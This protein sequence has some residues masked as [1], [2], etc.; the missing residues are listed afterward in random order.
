VTTVP[1][2]VYNILSE[3]IWPAPTF[4]IYISPR[5]DTSEGGSWG[6]EKV[7]QWWEPVSLR[8]GTN[9]SPSV[10]RVKRILGK[11]PGKSVHDRPEDLFAYPGDRFRLVEHVAGNQ[12][13][14]FTGWAGLEHIQ[15]QAEP[16]SEVYDWAVYGPEV[17]FAAAVIDGSWYKTPTVDDLEIDGQDATTSRFRD[18]VFQI[19]GKCIFNEGGKPN[20]SQYEWRLIAKSDDSGAGDGT[21]HSHVFEPPD[22][23]VTVGDS[24]TSSRIQAEHWDAA[25]AVVSLLHW[26]GYQT[27]NGLAGDWNTEAR[28][29][30]IRET[31]GGDSSPIRLGE[32]DVTGMSL[33][34]ALTA[35]LRPVG[36]GWCVTP[37]TTGDGCQGSE[38]FYR[39]DDQEFLVYSLSSPTVTK[40]PALASIE[41][42]NSTLNSQSAQRAQVQR[43]DMYRDNH[44][45]R[46]NVKVVGS[47]R[48]VQ[49]TFDYGGTDTILQP[50]WDTTANLLALDGDVWQGVGDEWDGKESFSEWFDAGGGSHDS[51]LDVFRSFILNEDGSWRGDGN[52]TVPDL[53]DFGTS[54]L[55]SDAAADT[56][57]VRRPRKLMPHL[58]TSTNGSTRGDDPQ[59]WMAIADSAGAIL[60]DSWLSVRANVMEDRC[61]FTLDES[62]L[63]TWHPWGQMAEARAD[64][65]VEPAGAKY[66]DVH[67]LTLL[68]N[69]LNDN[70]DYRLVL[71]VSGTIETD[72]VPTASATPANPADWPFAAER[73]VYAPGRFRIDK[74]RNGGFLDADGRTRLERDDTA[75]LD[76]EEGSP[77]TKFA[78]TVAESTGVAMGHGSLI[79]RCLTREYTPGMGIV[80][81]S[82]R[83]VN[84]DLDTA[85]SKFPVVQGVH[86]QFGGSNKTELVLDSP[87][88]KV[89]R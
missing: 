27:D 11:G 12:R 57:W 69:T 7:A 85:Y 30:A 74:V 8:W 47:P 18:N 40:E 13:E 75:A 77:I 37:W 34:D 71:R 6:A 51:Y 62:E 54:V 9:G 59:V 67:Y 17:T 43:L 38:E 10:L 22:R 88:A 16:A 64:D 81:T 48:I 70:G 15:I 36:Y 83:I 46:T 45:V 32:V 89:F 3:V 55:V 58:T 4:R 76:G 61:G 49:V 44:N 79:L 29:S 68:Y 53:K 66:A 52:A 24:D 26:F 73:L 63:S 86:W 72:Y 19:D 82:D 50:Y 35:I 5:I 23:R 25:S 80:G 33:A 87:L 1:L 78:S 39:Y 31:L 60:E 56:P 65:E 28:T 2:A 41:G 20:M 84:F 21:K 14:W 42:G